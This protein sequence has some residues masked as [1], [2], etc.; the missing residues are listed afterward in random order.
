MNFAFTLALFGGTAAIA[1]WITVRFP[2]L[3]PKSMRSRALGVGA[4]VILLR[5]A[6]ISTSGPTLMYLTMFALAVVLL[7][8]WLS[9]VWM[10]QGLRDLIA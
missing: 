5:V 7:L 8:V 2:K 10:L 6:P 9:A 3:G 1:A 4:S